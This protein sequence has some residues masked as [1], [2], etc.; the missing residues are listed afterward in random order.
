MLR[1]IKAIFFRKYSLLLLGKFT[2]CF[3]F[4]N[5]LKVPKFTIFI[6]FPVSQYS[7]DSNWK[8][9]LTP[10]NSSPHS[11]APP[12]Y[13]RNTDPSSHQSPSSRKSPLFQSEIH[14]NHKHTH[15]SSTNNHLPEHVHPHYRI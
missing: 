10:A 1:F 11:S 6:P 9:R 13:S 14:H 8:N 12:S 7:T 2:V 5:I 4:F 15:F 3:N